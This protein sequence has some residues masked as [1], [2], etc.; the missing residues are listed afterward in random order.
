MDTKKV[1][2]SQQLVA[3]LPP[4]ALKVMLWFINW[5]SQEVIKLYEKQVCKMLKLSEDELNVAVQTL[6]DNNLISVSRN[7]QVWVVQLEK[8]KIQKYYNVPMDVVKEHD[9]LPLSTKITWNVAETENKKSVPMDFEDM[10]EEQ[11]QKLL[12]RIEASL[13]EKQQVKKLV[14]NNYDDLP[15]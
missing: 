4:L 7:E 6:V 8:E 9:I 11:L 1:Y 12:M 15:F 13:S 10:S 5:Q 2:A 3:M 14:K